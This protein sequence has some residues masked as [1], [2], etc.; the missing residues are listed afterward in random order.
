ME[1]KANGEAATAITRECLWALGFG[2]A[3]I[4]GIFGEFQKLIAML[5]EK[6][7]PRPAREN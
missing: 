4:G 2:A 3:T 7:G 6:L 1:E 5:A